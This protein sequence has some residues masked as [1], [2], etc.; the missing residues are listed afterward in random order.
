MSSS[1]SRESYDAAARWLGEFAAP[2]EPSAIEEMAEGI[3]AFAGLLRGQPRLR[4]TLVDSGRSP[5]DRVR[6]LRSLLEG[7]L[8]A[9]TLELLAMLVAARWSSPSELLDAAERLGV[10]GLLASAQRIGDL[11]EVEDELFRF[12]KI[13]A[14]DPQLAAVLSDST[15]LTSAGEDRRVRLVH[16]LLEGKARPVTLRLGSLALAAPGGRGFEAALTWLVERA[17]ARREHEVAYVTVAAQLD[18]EEE[19]RLASALA[20]RYGHDISLKITVDSRVIGGVR[21]KVGSD[22]YDATVQRRL[23]EARSAMTK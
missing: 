1:T 6:L 14:G 18:P 4:R 22:L 19:S 12:G 13:V 15:A 9:Q 8:G 17:A 10:E 5:E 16:D 23:T 20:A 3:L 7:R 2:A 11:A 21:V